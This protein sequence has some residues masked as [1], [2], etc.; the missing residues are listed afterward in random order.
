MYK[1]RLKDN[2][3]FY[4]KGTPTYP[5]YDKN[6]R[7]FPTLGSLRT[8]ITNTMNS[9][10][11][12]SISNWEIVE[13]VMEVKGVKGVHEVITSDKLVKLLTK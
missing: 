11:S 2:P 10:R 8:F 9:R 3:N 4:V 13:Y 6:G 5:S 1:I 12:D 7:L